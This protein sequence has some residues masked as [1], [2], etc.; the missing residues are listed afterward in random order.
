MVVRAIH[1]GN[2]SNWQ[3]EGK[4]RMKVVPNQ[5]LY[6]AEP[7]PELNITRRTPIRRLLRVFYAL[8][9]GR[10]VHSRDCNSNSHSLRRAITLLRFT[11][12]QGR[13]ISVPCGRC[14]VHGGAP[15]SMVVNSTIDAHFGND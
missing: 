15:L 5:A 8:W 10:R 7:Q 6:Q 3:K 14:R 1:E 2:V 9:Q 4:N 13:A 11:P 12:D